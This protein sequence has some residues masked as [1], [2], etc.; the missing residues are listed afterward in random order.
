MT[1][2]LDE[3]GKVLQYVSEKSIESSKES[4]GAEEYSRT[5]DGK[6]Q[7]DYES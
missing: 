5:H 1:C 4:S 6:A 2:Q 7:D 3:R